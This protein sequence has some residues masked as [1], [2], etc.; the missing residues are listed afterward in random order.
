MSNQD[1]MTPAEKEAKRLVELFL[2]IR[3]HEGQDYEVMSH[4]MSKQCA[5]KCV[6]EIGKES[7]L[8]SPYYIQFWKLVKQAIEKYNP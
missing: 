4:A 3:H 8:R 1:N 7:E 6:E 5:L 2:S